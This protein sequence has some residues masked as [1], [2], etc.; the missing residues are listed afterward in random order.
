M[1]RR[2]PAARLIRH[3]RPVAARRGSSTVR[4]SCAALVRISDDDRYVLFSSES[5]PGAFTPPGGAFKYFAPAADL[6]ETWG[7]RPERWVARDSGMSADLRGRLPARAV[8]EFSRWFAAGVYREDAVECLRRELTE[9][10]DV[11]GFPEL[12]DH[13]GELGFTPLRTVVEGPAPVPG[14]SFKQLRHLEF[15][16]LVLASRSALVLHRTLLELSADPA[17]S[18][19][20]EASSSDI[21]HGRAG[22]ALIAP[23]AA[24]LIGD[25]RT[26]HDL[27]PLR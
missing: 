27:P 6:L 15:H 26:R 14:E 13:V 1:R 3:R 20:I 7:F 17:V 22:A 25:D 18:T 21:E 10:L 8:P 5:R 19:I 4:I 2:E 23:H 11:V 16:G 24:Y 9:E 12:A